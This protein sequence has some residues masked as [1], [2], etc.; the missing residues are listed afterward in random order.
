MEIIWVLVM[1]VAQGMTMGPNF[2]TEA[3]CK[4][5]VATLEKESAA[6]NG[7]RSIYGLCLPVKRVFQR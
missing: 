7:M 3:E 1:T 6:K 4:T 5:A 2:P